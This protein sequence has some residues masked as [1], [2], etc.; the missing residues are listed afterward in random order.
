MAIVLTDDGTLDT[1]LACEACGQEFR[2]N[3]GGEHGEDCNQIA[4]GDCDCYGRF[5]DDCI[6]DA[7]WEHECPK[8]P[9]P[10][11]R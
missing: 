8:H 3:F 7:D 9:S 6:A 5:V 10:E 1:V 11:L 2:F 4:N